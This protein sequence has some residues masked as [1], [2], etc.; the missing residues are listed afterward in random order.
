MLVCPGELRLPFRFA[1]PRDQA[2]GCGALE[3]HI[4]RGV[5]VLETN[6]DVDVTFASAILSICIRTFLR[7]GPLAWS[8]CDWVV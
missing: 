4:Q 6:H 5:Q 2:E 3:A 7:S 8:R 1:W